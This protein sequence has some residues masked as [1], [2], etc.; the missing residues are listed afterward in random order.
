MLC[1]ILFALLDQMP[2]DSVEACPVSWAGR[3][4]YRSQGMVFSRG[5][6]FVETGIQFLVARGKVGGFFDLD[7]ASGLYHSWLVWAQAVTP[8]TSVRVWRAMGSQQLKVRSWRQYVIKLG[9]TVW[10]LP[11]SPHLPS[12]SSLFYAGERKKKKERNMFGSYDN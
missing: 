3:R 9:R 7:T 10:K 6:L 1:F 2:W 4:T 11:D 5:P 8:K 12:W